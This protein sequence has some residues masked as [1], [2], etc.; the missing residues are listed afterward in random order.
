MSN[1][2]RAEIKAFRE[3]LVDVIS[4]VDPSSNFGEIADA[5][6]EAL[7]PEM[8]TAIREAVETEREACAQ[9]FDARARANELEA[10][11][12]GEDVGVHTLEAL[13]MHRGASL[14]RARGAK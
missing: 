9:M 6:L 12:K 5:V 11:A 7:A 8:R 3:K 4:Y 13:A 10:I 1:Q 14:V 2:K